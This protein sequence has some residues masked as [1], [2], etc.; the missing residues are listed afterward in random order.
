[1]KVFNREN[2]NMK[3]SMNFDKTNISHMKIIYSILA[4]IFLVSCSGEE[5]KLGSTTYYGTVRNASTNTPY[6]DICVSV[7]DGHATRTRT[8]TNSDGY[9]SLNVNVADLTGNFYILVS[10]DETT[11]K[12]F[13]ITGVTKDQVD[14][15]I[16]YL[17]AATP[18]EL[19][20]LDIS[21]ED[22]YL[23]FET[24]VKTDKPNT[25]QESGICYG[26]TA[27]PT[28]TDKKILAKL[29]DS[30]LSAKIKLT[31]LDAGT[32]YYFRAYS[33][34]NMGV[35]YSNVTSYH[36][37][38][39]IPRLEWDTDQWGRDYDEITPESIVGLRAWIADNGGYDISE[40]GFCY[41]EANSI[42]TIQDTK[43]VAKTD[44]NNDFSAT[45]IGL[46]PATK[47][48]VRPYAINTRKGI[49][50]GIVKVL[51]TY[52][53][54]AE[55]S[56]TTTSDT[57]LGKV[58]V[59]GSIKDTW[60]GTVSQAGICYSTNPNPTIDDNVINVSAK[61]GQFLVEFSIEYNKTYYIKAFAI[62]QYGISYSNESTEYISN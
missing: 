20:T 37:E 19:S 29:S 53:G 12:R 47:Y 26:L 4:L 16:I 48:Y 34:N 40:C 46:K 7:T 41:T 33:I 30:T 60:G 57:Y 50:Y 6:A 11:S 3:K 59:V 54:L 56:I 8:F 10:S 1:M 18:P 2:I 23:V 36:T 58:K 44:K 14:L 55:I 39:A 42:P 22:N 25:I 52:S 35:G 24:V 51:E 13:E 61:K 43:I 17:T 15:G 32:D 28:I 31:D 45:L 9:F 27:S 62:T 21:A 38:D 49:G 5:Y